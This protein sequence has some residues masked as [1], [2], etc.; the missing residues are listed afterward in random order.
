MHLLKTVLAVV[1]LSFFAGASYALQS[2][3]AMVESHLNQHTII[4]APASE[5]PPALQACISENQAKTSFYVYAILAGGRADADAI[6]PTIVATAIRGL[7]KPPSLLLI[8]EIIE[9]AVK[10]TPDAVLKIVRAAILNSP[11][12]AAPTIVE[13][14]VAS[15]KNPDQLVSTDAGTQNTDYKGF[16]DFKTV[17]APDQ[18]STPAEQIVQTALQANPSLDA[19]S[20]QTA[21]NNGL[22]VLTDIPVPNDSHFAIWP[23][24][25][26]LISQ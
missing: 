15:L 19:S 24:L 8:S 11:N 1:C 21:A 20:L 2:P 17:N 26:P 4:N 23:P 7:S 6:A 16:K 9:A 12:E 10:A 5:L 14:A 3:T 18:S 25:V 13:T 22:Q